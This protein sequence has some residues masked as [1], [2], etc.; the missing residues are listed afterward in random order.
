LLAVAA[1]RDRHWYL[2]CISNKSFVVSVD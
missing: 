1:L 2:L